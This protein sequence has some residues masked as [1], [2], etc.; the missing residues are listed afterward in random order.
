MVARLV[1]CSVRDANDA[2]N[3]DSAMTSELV[4]EFNDALALVSMDLSEKT[5]SPRR[6]C[7]KSIKQAPLSFSSP[8]MHVL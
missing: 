2:Q 7:D 3:G 6:K 8:S 5:R 4:T 1:I